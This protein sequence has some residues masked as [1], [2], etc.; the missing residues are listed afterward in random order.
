MSARL[1]PVWLMS[2]Y[3]GMCDTC[4]YS[5][6]VSSV[7]HVLCDA[8]AGQLW[9]RVNKALS[10][11]GRQQLDPLMKESKPSWITSVVLDRQAGFSQLH[12]LCTHQAYVLVYTLLMSLHADPTRISKAFNGVQ[13][14]R[15][16]NM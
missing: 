2:T 7:Q 8:C 15:I 16:P 9:P 13:D 4:E 5:C 12:H 14:Q 3:Q 1:S 6:F 10:T 11:M